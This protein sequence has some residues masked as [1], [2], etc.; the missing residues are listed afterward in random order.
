MTRLANKIGIVTRRV[1]G[2]ALGQRSTVGRRYSIPAPN[3]GWNTRD[4][5]ATMKEEYAIQ[6]DN[7]FPEVGSV[8]LRRGTRTHQ[9]GMGSDHVET[10]I[11]H[12]STTPKLFAAANDRIYDITV[13]GEPPTQVH[14][15]TTSNYWQYATFQ[16]NTICVNGED[17]PFRINPDG[18]FVAD[19]ELTGET[20]TDVALDISTLTYILPFKG[21]LLF[22]EKNSTRLW[23]LPTLGAIRGELSRIELGR[24]QTGGGHIVNFGTLTLDSGSGVDDLLCVFFSTGAVLVYEGTD[25]GSATDWSL[26]GVWHI[27]RLVGSK[28]LVSSAVILLP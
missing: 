1:G 22:L 12:E 24:V 13:L 6:L 11:P 17:D 8:R 3:K 23:F 16:G 28:P 10:L 19:T 15:G 25:P 20:A 18:T 4:T 26:V 5:W 9:K 14:S 27:G 21:R 2:D 7:Y